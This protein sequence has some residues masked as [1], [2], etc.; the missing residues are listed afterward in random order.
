MPFVVPTQPGIMTEMQ[1]FL[2]QMVA[3]PLLM[4]LR[5]LNYLWRYYQPAL[6]TVRPTHD[7]DVTRTSYYH[8]PVIPSVDGLRYNFETRFVC[9]AAAQN[10]TV[11]WDYTTAYAG[12]GTVWVNLFSNVVVSAGAA[13][14]TTRQDTNIQILATAVAVRV[15]LTAPAVGH[16][17]DQHFLA[18]PAP[19][20]PTAGLQVSGYAPFDDGLFLD[21]NLAPIHTEWLNRCKASTV[22]ILQDRKQMAFS[23]VQ[24]FV[25]I[26]RYRVG[27]IAGLAQSNSYPVA[28]CWLPGQAGNL[29][30]NVYGIGIVSGGTTADKMTLGQV[31]GQN[32][33]LDAT[34]NIDTGALSCNVT[35][36]GLLGFVDLR[37]S[38]SSTDFRITTPYA[39][40][41]YYTPGA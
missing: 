2:P 21:A 31:G 41:A 3:Q 35:T 38:A 40:V 23:F 19:A 10:V 14:L 39:V 22:A 1:M 32:V 4:A 7:P 34:G 25:A 15:S 6:V 27:A 36:P 18:Y 28:R 17:N 30:L 13:A 16:R 12:A 26:P 29:N 11:A 24:E 8:I 20:A 33:T 37:R 9:S 5:N